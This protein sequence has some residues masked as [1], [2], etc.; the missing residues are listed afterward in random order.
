MTASLVPLLAF[1][2][3]ASAQ[4][5]DIGPGKQVGAPAPTAQAQGLLQGLSDGSLTA[6]HGTMNGVPF[7]EWTDG[8]ARVL[9]GYGADGKPA[10]IVAHEPVDGGVR[11]FFDDG[12]TGRV[13]RMVVNKQADPMGRANARMQASENEMKAFSSEDA[14]AQDAANTADMEPE[15]VKVYLVGADGGS[16]SLVDY[17]TGQRTPAPADQASG[18]ATGIQKM[19][20]AILAKAAPAGR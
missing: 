14:L 6:G 7:K 5:P 11:T 16:L 4:V 9:V 18:L 10:W 3:A 12:A 19:Y 2:L 1:A 17:K 15:A 8:S 20:Q 13:T